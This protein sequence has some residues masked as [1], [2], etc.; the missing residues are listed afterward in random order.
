MTHP[1]VLQRLLRPLALAVALAA[2]L[3]AALPAR[4]APAWLTLSA[5]ALVV[6]Q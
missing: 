1:L 5:D 6:L 3:A 2:G 4:A